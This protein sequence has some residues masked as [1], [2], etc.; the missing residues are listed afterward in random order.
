MPPRA[1]W[2]D[3][4]EVLIHAPESTVKQHP[5]YRAAKSGDDLAARELVADT[6][7]AGKVRAL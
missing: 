7:D 5:A 4:A 1:A 6:M 3:F 2:D